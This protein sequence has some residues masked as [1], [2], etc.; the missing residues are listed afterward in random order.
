MID[1]AKTGQLDP[2]VAARL[3]QLASER[4]GIITDE[5]RGLLRP[6]FDL[7]HQGDVDFT[8]I[9]ECLALTP[10]E[11]LRRHERGRLF[12]KEVVPRAKLIRRGHR[13][14]GGGER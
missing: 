13:T 1:T 10:T 14:A 11:R 12:V 3:E 7:G 6:Y 4:P 5:M 9:R 8:Q 2:E